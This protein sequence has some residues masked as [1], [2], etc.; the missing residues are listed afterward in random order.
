MSLLEQRALDPIPVVKGRWVAGRPP[1]TGRRRR[2]R[3]S[4]KAVSAGVICRCLQL[5]E[6]NGSYAS[7][8]RRGST[9]KMQASGKSLRKKA[10]S[11][12]VQI[13]DDSS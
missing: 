11:R 2:N 13:I 6:E 12:N 8:A 9:S 1:L 5:R 3:T 10:R 7:L 4:A